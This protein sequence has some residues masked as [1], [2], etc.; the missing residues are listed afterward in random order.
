MERTL[1]SMSNLFAQLGRPNDDAAIALFIETHAPLPN[2]TRLHEAVFWTSAEAVFLAEAVSNDADWA[3][4]A[5]N[6]NS[7]LHAAPR[8]HESAPE[9]SAESG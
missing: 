8:E 4:V 6:L 9:S 3:D 7:L 5:E 1:H 2:E